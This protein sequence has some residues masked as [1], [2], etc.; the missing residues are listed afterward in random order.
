MRG[1]AVSLPSRK[2]AV[3]HVAKRQLALE[4]DA[5]RDLLQRVAGVTSSANLNEDGFRAVLAELEA[6]GFRSEFGKRHL[7]NRRH[8]SMASPA[9]LALLNAL[10]TEYTDCKGTE[11]SLGKWLDR[12]GW[13]SALRFLSA[14]DAQK[15]IGAL[16]R[17]QE[18]KAAKATPG[19]AD[20]G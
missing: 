15:A 7:G 9:Q 6:A 12:Q 19:G 18:H 8:W 16:R 20:A 14:G 11:R 4:D 13:A 17:M 5:Y 10:W 3:I 1:S 2:I